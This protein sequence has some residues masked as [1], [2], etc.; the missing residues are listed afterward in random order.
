MILMSNNVLTY[1]HHILNGRDY[2]WFKYGYFSFY[3]TDAGDRE[4]WGGLSRGECMNVDMTDFFGVESDGVNVVFSLYGS[5]N[6]GEE[7]NI[8]V[9]V[10]FVDCKLAFESA[11]LDRYG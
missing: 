10:P 6:V 9:S 4:V 7:H 11:F 5:S 8:T 3:V 2:H 1:S